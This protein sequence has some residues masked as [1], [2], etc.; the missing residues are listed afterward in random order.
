MERLRSLPYKEARAAV[1]GDFEAQYL[2]RLLERAG[3]NVSEAAR[4]ARMDR[5]Y[6]IK[7]LTRHG[8]KYRW[9]LTCIGTRSR[10]CRRARRSR[11]HRTPCIRSGCR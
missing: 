8:L 11:Q 4:R 6:L 3:G 9:A 5:T 7:L 1:L 10:P 2:P